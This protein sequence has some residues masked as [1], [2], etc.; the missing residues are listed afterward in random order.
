MAEHDAHHISPNPPLKVGS[1]HLPKPTRPC[2]LQKKGEVVGKHNASP[3][4]SRKESHFEGAGIFLAK[5]MQ[6]PCQS[7]ATFAVVN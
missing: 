4:G 2:A 6:K 5:S 1:Q 7:Y 3:P